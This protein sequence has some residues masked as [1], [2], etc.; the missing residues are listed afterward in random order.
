MQRIFVYGTLKRG[1]SNSH[2]MAG[3]TFVGEAQTQPVYRLVDLGEYPGM[4]P[5]E[6]EGLSIKGEIWEVDELCK[7]ALDVLEGVAEG[8]YELVP[9]KLL[10]PYDDL[11]V[12]T[13]LYR[14]PHAG[15]PDAGEEWTED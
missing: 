11:G 8:M 2:F 10:P 12:T 6:S 7:A 13:Y 15:Q 5:V 14:W 9:A 1:L 4:I 3:Q